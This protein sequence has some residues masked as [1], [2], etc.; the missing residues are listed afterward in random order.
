MNN[1]LF[2]S[3]KNPCK[4]AHASRPLL[5]S[6]RCTTTHA[7]AAPTPEDPEFGGQGVD[8]N[9]RFQSHHPQPSA[10]PWPHCPPAPSR[11]G[12]RAGHVRTQGR[13]SLPLSVPGVSKASG[14][15]TK[16]P[17]LGVSPAA[18]RHRDED[19]CQPTPTGG[20]PALHALSQPPGLSRPQPR[21]PGPRTP[22]ATAHECAASVA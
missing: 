12:P 2:Q 22:R 13:L 1:L 17:S 20:R 11:P 3:W 14:K 18:L 9:V 19:G 10:A 7:V 21:H 5:H 8:V 6:T 16:K 15:Q 4:T